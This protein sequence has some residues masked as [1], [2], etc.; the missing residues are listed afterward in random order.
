M[1]NQ[2]SRATGG[3]S[4]P[5]SAAELELG[6]VLAVIQRILPRLDQPNRA[7]EVQSALRAAAGWIEAARTAHEKQR[8]AG[9]AAGP[10]PVATAVAPEIAA[11]IAAA[12][13]VLFDRPYRLVSVQPVAATVPHLN[14][15]ALEGRTQ[16][17]QS[18]KVR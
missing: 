10:Q 17:F 16:I 13:A 8:G 7:S 15:W 11:V 3:S 6:K 4:E 18:H 12:I 1:S 5:L 2:E 9:T 14:V